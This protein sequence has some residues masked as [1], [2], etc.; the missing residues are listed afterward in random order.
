MEK[1][2]LKP[3]DKESMRMA[4]LKHEEMFKEQVHELH[5]LYRIQ[6]ILMRSIAGRRPNNTQNNQELWNSKHSINFAQKCIMTRGVETPADQDYA[7]ESS[8]NEHRAVLEIIDESEIKLTLGP[9]SYN[10][11]RRNKKNPHET[12]LTSDSG[13]SSFSSSSTGSSN[14]INKTTISS[15]IH[16]KMNAKTEESFGVDGGEELREERLNQPPWLF[17]VLSLNMT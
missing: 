15:L 12:P 10:S 13:P 2:I 6:K 4:M 8:G 9:S 7:A 5:R 3:Y 1:L 14:I 17:Q 16:R 11:T